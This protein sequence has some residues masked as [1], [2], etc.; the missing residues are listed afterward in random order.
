MKR[1]CLLVTPREKPRSILKFSIQSRSPHLVLVIKHG[2]L[3]LS[4]NMGNLPLIR[5]FN[6]KIIELNSGF[7]RKQMFEYWTRWSI[8]PETSDHGSFLK[9]SG[10]EVPILL[11][12]STLLRLRSPKKYGILPVP[13]PMRL[14]QRLLQVFLLFTQ[15]MRED[16][17]DGLQHKPGQRQAT[18][19]LPN[20]SKSCFQ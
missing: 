1:P 11:I 13:W 10:P 16:F 18:W 14:S 6:G 17:V 20:I 2:N 12:D 8:F 7:S 15:A 19:D 4:I 5:Y 9:S 3:K